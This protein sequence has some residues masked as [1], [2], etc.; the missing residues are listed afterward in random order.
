MLRRAKSGWLV[1]HD[2]PL[3][4]VQKIPQVDVPNTLQGVDRSLV[5]KTAMMHGDATDPDAITSDAFN[6]HEEYVLWKKQR[7]AKRTEEIIDDVVGTVK[8]TQKNETI[9]DRIDSRREIT[10]MEWAKAVKAAKRRVIDHAKTT[11]PPF[12]RQLKM[13]MKRKRPQIRAISV[14]PARY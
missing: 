7:N 2:I 1:P 12:S 4:G 8:G 5:E 9:L 6:S 10:A 3:F 13:V 11:R 14:T